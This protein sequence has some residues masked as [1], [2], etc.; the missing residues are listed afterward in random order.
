MQKRL[1]LVVVLCLYLTG[2]AARGTEHTKDSVDT[3][4]KAVAEKKA[5]LLD[6]REQTEWDEGHLGDAKLLPL[7]VLKDGPDAKTLAKV[8]VKDKVIYAHCRSGRRCLE[9][10]DI[11]RK[12]GY[13][14]R[15]LKASFQELLEAGFHRADK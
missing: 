12:Q 7:S 5:I 14:V 2:V 9:A 13:D 10:A 4:R 8:L 3:V 15:P 11:L 6:V 1:L